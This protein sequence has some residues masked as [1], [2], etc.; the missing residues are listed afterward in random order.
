MDGHLMSMPKR[1]QA[2]DIPELPILELL[3]AR[4]ERHGEYS[5]VVAVVGVLADTGFGAGETF[6]DRVTWIAPK[7]DRAP[8]P[9]EPE[10]R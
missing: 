10:R 1:L 3:A 5:C 2:K 9:P 8:A 7:L 6:G 4:R